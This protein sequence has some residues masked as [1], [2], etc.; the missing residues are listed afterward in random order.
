MPYYP[1]VKLLLHVSFCVVRGHILLLD[2]KKS[3]FT[4]QTQAYVVSEYSR[5]QLLK[6]E[7]D[8][9]SLLIF[10]QILMM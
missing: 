3:Q 4:Y 10:G 6:S 7:G 1:Y 2:Q 9:K 5:A 8:Q